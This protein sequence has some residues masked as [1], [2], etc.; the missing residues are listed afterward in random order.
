[1]RKIWLMR[2]HGRF[3]KNRRSICGT[4]GQPE[5]WSNQSSDIFVCDL[6]VGFRLYKLVLPEVGEKFL[7]GDGQDVI[8]KG[9]YRILANQDEILKYTLIFKII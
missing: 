9:A 1:M 2:F 5:G 4:E 7:P 8:G 3:L 6:T